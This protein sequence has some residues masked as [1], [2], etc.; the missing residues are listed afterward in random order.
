MKTREELAAL[1]A[2][3][4]SKAATSA[5]IGEGRPFWNAEGNQFMY[6]PAFHFPPMPGAP[7]YR[8]TAKDE[9]GTV[10]TFEADSASAS[11]EPIWKDI[12]EGVV[13]LVVQSLDPDGNAQYTVG[14]RTFFRLAP[15]PADTPEPVLSFRECA[16]RAY[17]YAM[18]QKFLLHWRDKG[19]PDPE[20]NLNVY[21]AK[22]IS[23][24]VNAM[25]YY[26]TLRPERAADARKIAVNAADY[27]LSITPQSG[28]M[29]GLP[30]TYYIDFR[31]N[32]EKQIN[33]TAADRLGTNMMLY[34]ASAG[35]A[36][37]KLEKVTKDP[38]YLEAALVIGEFFR[39][40]VE[41][42]G[43]WYLVRDAKTGEPIGPDFISPM[44]HITPFLMDLYARTKDPIWKKLADGTVAYTERSE[45]V[46]YEWGGQFEDS[47]CSA[48]YSNL[49]HFNA[50][51]LIRHYCRYYRDDPEKMAAAVDLGRFIEDQFVI[52][53][54]PAPWDRMRFKT[55]LWLTPC[56]L[57]QYKWYVP[58]D[59]SAAE[60]MMMFLELYRAGQ[61]D[62]YLA[63]AK[64]LG[65]SITRSQ[66]ENGMIPTHWMEPRHLKGDDFW[67][68]CMFATAGM[69]TE[70][71]EAVE[72]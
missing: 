17:D 5:H 44:H 54:R 70:F 4:C 45:A 55:D 71:A 51:S 65:A 29:R 50:S 57:E 38:K 16:A 58:I 18:T 30:P 48:N 9:T 37:L 22:M 20:Y 64:A 40:H 15:F 68:N 27:L 3:E 66:Q 11:L 28:P 39:D 61:G 60:I 34:P 32:P 36:Y 12:P 63:K 23:A 25:L 14:T 19:T 26:E 33:F 21:P 10:H 24:T 8:Y 1:A 6:V 49:T 47:F 52:W 41:E 56:G 35:V 42:N 7:K 2:E 72:A 31:E 43:S 69:L 62:L 59:D 53:K 46:N 67:I 13:E